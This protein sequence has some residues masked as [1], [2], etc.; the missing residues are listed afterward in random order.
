MTWTSE[1]AREA[2]SKGGK[3][4]ALRSTSED[5]IAMGRKG[6][7]KTAAVHDRAHYAAIGQKGGNK[8]KERGSEYFRAIGSKRWE[9]RGDR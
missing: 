5:Y 3:A 6:G 4:K 2:G 1:T 9:N 8:T 7:T